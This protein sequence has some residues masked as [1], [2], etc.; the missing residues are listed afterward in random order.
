M[1]SASTWVR[2]RAAL[3]GY[4]YPH[5]RSEIT[6]HAKRKRPA[7]GGALDSGAV[8]PPRIF[9]DHVASLPWTEMPELATMSVSLVSVRKI[10]PMMKVM[11]ATPIG[12]QS[13]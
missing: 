9:V 10:E 13:P 7:N 2:A 5:R 8:L 11:I 12:Y 3:F 1:T 4:R 6:H